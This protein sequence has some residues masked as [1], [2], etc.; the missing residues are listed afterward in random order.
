MIDQ[1]L[2]ELMTYDINSDL[3]YQK[4]I[5]KALKELKFRLDLGIYAK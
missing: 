4:R 2:N 1:K 3:Q 5:I